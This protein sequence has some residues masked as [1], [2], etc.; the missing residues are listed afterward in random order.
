MSPVLNCRYSSG[1]PRAQ[2]KAGL[3]QLG[4]Q[5]EIALFQLGEPAPAEGQ[6]Q[7]VTGRALIDTGAS[8]TCVDRE[9]A[10][11]AGLSIVGSGPMTSATHEHEIVPI[12][13][14]Q[15]QNHRLPGGRNAVCDGSKS[16]PSRTDR[17]DRARFARELRAGRQ[18]AGRV[19]LPLDLTCAHQP[20]WPRST[21]KAAR[22]PGHQPAFFFVRRWRP[23]AA[24]AGLARSG[25]RAA[26]AGGSSK[27]SRGVS[28]A[29]AAT[30]GGFR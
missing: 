4:P 6:P 22:T 14:R 26:A 17:A 29:A 2:G 15:D 20:R 10:E 27:S 30:R 13:R 16:A 5:V 21:P 9:A 1:E 19:F 28:G 7:P 8:V 3:R 23:S 12:L 11:T 25:S 24:F 18:R